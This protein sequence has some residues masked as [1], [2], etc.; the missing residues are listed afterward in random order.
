MLFE[1][2]SNILTLSW[3]VRKC[4]NVLFSNIIILGCTVQNKGLV[5]K[6]L[7]KQRRK[8]NIS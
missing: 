1:T 2:R 8:L 7:R 4:I 6:L 3:H 5:L